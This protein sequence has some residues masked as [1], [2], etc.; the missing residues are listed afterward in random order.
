MNKS[1]RVSVLAAAIAATLP[2]WVGAAG[3]GGI[4]VFSALGQPLRAEI[5]LQAAS[6]ELDGMAALVP[7]PDV[8]REA[9]LPYSNLMQDLEIT[10]D[11]SSTRPVLRVN[12]RRAVNEPFVDILVEL[13]WSAGRVTRE[14][15]LLLDPVERRPVAA[16]RGQAQTQAR[17]QEPAAAGGLSGEHRVRGGETLHRIAMQYMPEGAHHEQ[18]LIA[19]L[20]ANENAFADG[21]IN[22]LLANSRLDIPDEDAVAAVGV[23]EAREQVRAQAQAFEAYRRR[24]AG[25]AASRPPSSEPTP[26]T[27]RE[28]R[29]EPRVEEVVRGEGARDQVQVSGAPIPQAPA[30]A[31]APAAVADIPPP[32]APGAV[33]AEEDLVVISRQLDEANSRIAEL[34]T[35]IRD[36]QRAFEMNNRLQAEREGASDAPAAAA[37]SPRPAP[38]PAAPPPAQPSMLESLTANPM[39]LAGGALVLALLALLGIRIARRRREEAEFMDSPAYAEPHGDSPSVVSVPAGERVDTDTSSNGP[40]SV[41][42]T[43]FS[44]TGLSAIDANEGVDPVAEADVYLAYGRDAQAEEILLDALKVDASRHAIYLKLLEV[45]EQR[46]D[47]KQ[48]EAIATDLFGRTGGEGADWQ[49]A[50]AMGQRID[51]DNPLYGGSGNTTVPPA[52]GALGGAAA[53]TVATAA[54]AEESQA[55]DAPD[56][57]LPELDVQPDD[58]QDLSEPE[59]QDELASLDF[60]LDSVAEEPE[61]VAPADSDDTAA[62]S[63][64]DDNMLAFDL[65]LGDDTPPAEPLAVP[66]SDTRADAVP[67]ASEDDMPPT[68]ESTYMDLEKTEF[69]ANVLD[70]DLD[71]SSPA[72]DEVGHA[73]SDGDMDL[74]TV[75]PNLDELQANAPTS[76]DEAHDD[77]SVGVVPD[78]AAEDV[79]REMDTKLELA[80]AYD[81]MG[82]REGARELLEEV[83]KEGSPEQREAAERMIE[84]LA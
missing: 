11:R 79:Q 62:T 49:K 52:G 32:A 67:V 50:V 17:T 18:M 77:E 54:I 43:D 64:D 19:L 28:G 38:R 13:S 6:D 59:E 14:Y 70:F 75:D 45:Y 42:D 15:T 60:D 65:D 20:R 10:I 34:E 73:S 55:D 57:V 66:G 72:D 1:L 63:S 33:A 78:F 8:F 2:S 24:V 30:Q 7:G 5:E 3:L 22:R 16:A 68:E 9:G 74:S 76:A 80:R 35:T 46:G 27:Q 51:P 23:I 12:S 53:A 56:A 58:T 47:R 83:V 36:M 82:D 84:K 21:N 44:Q 25:A 40:S 69:D 37:E 61:T 31:D 4:N 81:E 29:V 41:L 48:F 26:S 39:L 71:L